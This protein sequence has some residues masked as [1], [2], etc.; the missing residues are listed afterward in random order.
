MSKI[1]YDLFMIII[2]RFFQICVMVFYDR[3]ERIDFLKGLVILKRN[4]GV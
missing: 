3:R 1:F 2:F 4:G